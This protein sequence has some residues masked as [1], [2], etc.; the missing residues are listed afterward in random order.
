MVLGQYVGNPESSDP[1][2]QQGYLEDPTVPA[3]SL[4]A[5]FALTVLK[6]DNERWRGVPFIIRAGKGKFFSITYSYLYSSAEV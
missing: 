6:V 5:T 4:A 2:E 1:R 3:G